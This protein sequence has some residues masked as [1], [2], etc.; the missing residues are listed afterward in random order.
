MFFPS[1]DDMV[2]DYCGFLSIPDR[3]QEVSCDEKETIITLEVPGV[4]KKDIDVFTKDN[5]LT[6]KVKSTR[7]SFDRTYIIYDTADLEKI[8][9]LLDKGILIIKVPKIEE[10]VKKKIEIKVK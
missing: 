9:A 5:K 6:I 10:K 2:K 1:F 8:E 3:R 4:D 7:L